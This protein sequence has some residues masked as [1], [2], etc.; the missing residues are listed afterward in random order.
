M[1]KQSVIQCLLSVIMVAYLAVA[2]SYASGADKA[3]PYSGLSINI[4]QNK[5]AG[6]V[7]AADID[8]ELGSLSRTI[9]HTPHGKINT[10]Q[11]EHKLLSADNIESANCVNL[12]DGSLRI[13]V[14]PLEPVAR[15]FDTSSGRN[16]YINRAGKKMRATTRYRLDLP[17][18]TGSFGSGRSPAQALPVIDYLEQN[19]E[20]APMASSLRV[21]ALGDIILIPSIRGHVINLGD[22]TALANKFERLSVFYHK[23]MPVKGWEYYDT[24]SVKFSGQIV[25]KIHDRKAP[26]PPEVILD[27]AYIDDMETMQATTNP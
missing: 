12:N 5:A 16:Y 3:E 11:I 23:V 21:N 15:V 8:A 24:I 26:P 9:K 10:L 2:L 14:V 22:S 25:A 17:V 4:A 1:T 6:F 27:E 7:T 20:F 18:V 13:D 19:P